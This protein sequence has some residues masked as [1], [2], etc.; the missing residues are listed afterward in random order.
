MAVGKT[1]G[2]STRITSAPRSDRYIVQPGPAHTTVR[3]RTRMPSSGSRGGSRSARASEPAE[4]A[5]ASLAAASLTEAS[6]RERSAARA[7]VAA[8]CSPSNGAGAGTSGPASDGESEPACNRNGA[9]SW[10]TVPATGWVTSTKT[11]RETKCSSSSTSTGAVRG[12]TAHLWTCAAAATLALEWLNSH[13]YKAVST[14]SG[15]SGSNTH[16][17]LAKRSASELPSSPSP[18]PSPAAASVCT[19]RGTHVGSVNTSAQP[20]VT[21]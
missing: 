12:V 18:S 14:M 13:G 8:S 21:G 4:P 9:V 3:S 10:V 6:R 11:P 1:N 17:G 15:R 19:I 2:L 5:D 7:R 16:R 20:S